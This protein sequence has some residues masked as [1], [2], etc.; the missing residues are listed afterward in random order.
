MR[1][2]MFAKMTVHPRDAVGANR[3]AGYAFLGMA[4]TA[5]SSS[6]HFTRA[7]VVGSSAVAGDSNTHEIRL[8]GNATV[9]EAFSVFRQTFTVTLGKQSLTFAPDVQ[10]VAKVNGPASGALRILNSGPQG[11]VYGGTIEFS[12]T[13]RGP[14]WG[15]ELKQQGWS[16]T[17]AATWERP[18]E[19]GI[20]IGESRHHAS[21]PLVWTNGDR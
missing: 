16:P 10:G 2:G 9:F 4:G 19:F 21:V 12:V 7:E 5:S 14:A 15:Q 13:L 1:E 11:V 17:D 6:L 3:S 18:R 8:E 20:T